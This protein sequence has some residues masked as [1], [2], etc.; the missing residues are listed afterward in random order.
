MSSS[1]LHES[2]ARVCHEANRA[3]CIA[4]GDQ[5][6]LTWEQ[7]PQWQ[8]ESAIKGV[9]FHIDNPNAGP[10]ASHTA[11]MADKLAA[12]WTWGSTKDPEAKKH[13]CLVQFHELPPEQQAKDHIFRA[14]V[15]AH[16]KPSPCEIHFSEGEDEDTGE[17]EITVGV[18]F[19]PEI[20]RDADGELRPTKAQEAGWELAR[21]MMGIAAGG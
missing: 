18:K 16:A 7:A 1:D 21:Q 9:Q 3:L 10:E 17:P 15:H 20:K 5:S 6:Q 14:I 13:P 19:Y 4:F 8:R 2:I 12:G 11:W